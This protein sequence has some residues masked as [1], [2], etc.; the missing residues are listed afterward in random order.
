MSVGMRVWHLAFSAVFDS[1]HLPLTFH[2]RSGQHNVKSFG[3]TSHW[4]D[5]R[6][7][8]AQ[9]RVHDYRSPEDFVISIAN[10][11]N[12][13]LILAK[14]PQPA[15]LDEGIRSVS[16]RIR[17]SRMSPVARE[18]VAEEDLVIPTLELSVFADFRKELEHPDAALG[19]RLLVAKQELQFRLDERGAVV[20]SEAELVGENGSYEY[21]PGTRTFIFDK[22]FLIM[23]REAPEKQPYF[24]GWIGNT[25]LMIPRLAKSP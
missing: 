12:E 4:A 24:A 5:W 11:S 25:D 18:V 15:T 10:L 22:P 8:L 20:H 1:F 2:D 19:T 23:L 3:V 9:V 16:D 13:D 6:L 14:I 7:A 21:K 17:N